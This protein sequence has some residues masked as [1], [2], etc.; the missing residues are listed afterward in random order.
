MGTDRLLLSRHVNR[1]GDGDGK[2]KLVVEAKGGASLVA[3]FVAVAVLL[4]ANAGPASASPFNSH[5]VAATCG[6]GQKRETLGFVYLSM[7][8]K[9][10]FTGVQRLLRFAQRV[11]PKR[12]KIKLPGSRWR[13]MKTVGARLPEFLFI[14]SVKTRSSSRSWNRKPSL[15]KWRTR[16]GRRHS[17]RFTF[18]RAG[19]GYCKH[20]GD[21][22]ATVAGIVPGPGE[23]GVYYGDAADGTGL[24][25]IH[26]GN[27]SITAIEARAS[28]GGLTYA[29]DLPRTAISEGCALRTSLPGGTTP[30]GYEPPASLSGSCEN[31]NSYKVTLDDRA[32]ERTFTLSRMSAEPGTY[33]GPV[34]DE[35]SGKKW[36]DIRFQILPDGK[37]DFVSIRAIGEIIATRGV[38]LEHSNCRLDFTLDRRPTPTWRAGLRYD[39]TSQCRPGNRF[40]GSAETKTAGWGSLTWEAHRVG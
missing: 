10:S 20:R 28:R 22:L 5:G 32:G 9:R 6:K 12:V 35:K 23:A 25:F 33:T 1:R 27:G 24:S 18:H 26:D 38:T 14:Q 31:G 30:L 8:S 34:R 16:D 29:V 36:G 15:L 11:Q 13:S 17:Q 2:V 7:R 3:A 21:S 40:V 37:V 4:L 19:K 39:A